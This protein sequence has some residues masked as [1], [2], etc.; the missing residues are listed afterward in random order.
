M[1]RNIPRN[2]RDQFK[3]CFPI[4]NF[5][6]LPIGGL[7]FLKKASTGRIDHV[8]MKTAEN[9]FIHASEKCGMVE[10]VSLGDDCFFSGHQ[11]YFRKKIRE[12]VFGMPKNRK[13]FF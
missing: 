10:K 7:I 8:M 12:A 5:S 2:A 13:A 4:K 1:G 6:S 9:Q 11:L 3:D